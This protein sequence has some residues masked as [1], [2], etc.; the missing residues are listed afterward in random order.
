LKA[1]REEEVKTTGWKIYET[2]RLKPEW[3]R[4]AVMDKQSGEP[5]EEE[6]I[7]VER[8]LDHS[9]KIVYRVEPAKGVDGWRG[10]WCVVNRQFGK[11]REFSVFTKL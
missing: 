10:K 4:E 8:I 3:K 7:L 6:A 1:V 5:K 2:G 9:E 11:D